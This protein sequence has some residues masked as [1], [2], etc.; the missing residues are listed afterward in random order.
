MEKE[1]IDLI[2]PETHNLE[3]VPEVVDGDARW[4]DNEQTRK[5]KRKETV[6]EGETINGEIGINNMDPKV[7]GF[8]GLSKIFVL[9]QGDQ[10]E[11]TTHFPIDGDKDFGSIE[12]ELVGVEEKQGTMD[13]IEKTTYE[14]EGPNSDS[15]MED[16]FE[17]FQASIMEERGLQKI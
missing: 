3:K 8:S 1:L 17:E 10:I 12:E 7:L 13:P 16:S 6:A 11:E 9:D 14:E 5:E 15:E 2:W 4:K